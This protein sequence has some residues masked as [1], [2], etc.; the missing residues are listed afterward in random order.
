MEDLTIELVKF[1]LN[2]YSSEQLMASRNIALAGIETKKSLD[3]QSVLNNLQGMSDTQQVAALKQYNLEHRSLVD[4]VTVDS[5][6]RVVLEQ[7]H[8][9]STKASLE[10]QALVEAL[11]RKMSIKGL[12]TGAQN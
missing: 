11:S 10:Y 2:R 12:V 3:F 5:G 9:L 6:Q 7:E 8:A 1:A 4:E